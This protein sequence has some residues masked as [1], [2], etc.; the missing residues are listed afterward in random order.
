MTVKLQAPKEV[1]RI[2]FEL[3]VIT[4][5]VWNEVNYLRM[6]DFK[7]GRI[8]DFNRSGKIVYEKYKREVGSATVQQVCRKN[9]DGWR[10]FFENLGKMRSGEFPKWFKPKPPGY[11]EENHLI[12][13]RNDQYRIEGN[14][15]ILK[16]LGKFGRVEVSPT[17]QD[18]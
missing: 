3:A 12:I 1:E 17:S 10:S 15:L 16:G 7:E 2:P 18:F 4:G 13:L 11:R 9:A 5:K 6:R 8:V 14:K